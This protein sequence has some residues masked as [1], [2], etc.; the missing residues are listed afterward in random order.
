MKTKI[1]GR[2]GLEVT[3]IGLGNDIHRQSAV[4]ATERFR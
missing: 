3:I 4:G 2:T 1:L